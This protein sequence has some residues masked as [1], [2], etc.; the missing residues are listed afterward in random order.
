VTGKKEEEENKLY[1]YALGTQRV[2]ESI[3]DENLAKMRK[4]Q[5][6]MI[7]RACSRITGRRDISCR[8][9]SICN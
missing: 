4:I 1:W 3:G 2:M 9:V 5:G 7:R 8:E 6:F